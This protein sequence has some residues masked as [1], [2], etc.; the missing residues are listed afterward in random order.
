MNVDKMTII[1]NL[2]QEKMVEKMV[3]SITHQNSLSADLQDMVQMIYVFLLEYDEQKII[4]LWQNN[5][6]PFFI[7]RIIINQNRSDTSLY[8][9]T[10]RRYQWKSVDI[11]GMDWTDE[12]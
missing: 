3:K 7:A 4:D 1:G 9:Y 10:I 6:L 8:H 11:T 12:D 5:Q 2:A